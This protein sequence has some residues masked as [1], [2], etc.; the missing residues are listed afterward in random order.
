MF[1][2]FKMETFIAT[3]TLALALAFSPASYATDS[4]AK[5]TQDVGKKVEQQQH[6]QTAQK[7]KEVLSEATAAIRETENAL[8]AL[9]ENKNKEALAMLERAAGKLDVILAREPRLALAPV[10]VSSSTID[11]LTSIDAVKALV[12][13]AEDALGDGRVQ[14]ARALISNLASETVISVS[15]LPMA[16][17]PDAIKDAVHLIDQGKPEAAKVVLQ[18]ALNSL[19]VTNTVIPL[20]IVTA[21]QLLVSAEELAEKVDRS[22]DESKRLATLLKDARTELKFA[23]V[24]G[25]GSKKDF[26]NLYEQLDKIEDKTDDGKSGTGFFTKIKGYIKDMVKFSQPEQSDKQ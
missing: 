24:L 19:V 2:N 4:A 25:Y 18:T 5:V 20:P 13:R 15:H 23:Q 7:R 21:E 3:G 17:Y 12:N 14:E 11:V 26:K 1:R 22:D 16:T 6:G 10:A 8:K 9:D